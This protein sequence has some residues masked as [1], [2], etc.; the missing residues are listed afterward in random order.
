MSAQLTILAFVEIYALRAKIHTDI[1]VFTFF[2]KY[3]NSSLGKDQHVYFTK[4]IIMV[5][6]DQRVKSL[7]EISNSCSEWPCA[8]FHSRK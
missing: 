7:A 2:R 4:K 8:Q 5:N 6:I 3:E 1:L